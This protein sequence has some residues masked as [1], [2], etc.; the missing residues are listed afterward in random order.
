LPKNGL[1]PQTADFGAAGY[2]LFTT[3]VRRRR[4]AEE[5][6]VDRWHRPNRKGRAIIGAAFWSTRW[7]LPG[8]LWRIPKTPHPAARRLSAEDLPERRSATIS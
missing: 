5:F 1:I 3:R 8:T 2:D 6:V 7:R 4:S